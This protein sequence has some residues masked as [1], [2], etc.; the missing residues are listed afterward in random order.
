MYC[1]T[2][3]NKRLTYLLKGG[4][5]VTFCVLLGCNGEDIVAKANGHELTR[6]EAK[7]IMTKLGYNVNSQEEWKSFVNDWCLK[8]AMI[9]EL[10]ENGDENYDI[11]HIRSELFFGEMAEY[12]LT[13]NLLISQVDTIVSQDEMNEYYDSHTEEFTLQDFIVKVLYMK[14]PQKAEV[15]EQI[16]TAYLLK[17]DKDMARIESY[18]KLYAEDFYFDD[19]NWLFFSKIRNKLPVRNIDRESLVL[20]RTKTYFSD[21]QFVYFLNILDYKVKDDVS[22]MEFVEKEV[23]ERILTNR[24]NEKREKIRQQLNQEL[25]NKHEIEIYL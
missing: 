16:K 6:Y 4:L 3:A 25:K 9:D 5:L 8:M 11:A 20:N 13:E 2:L 1:I 21:D 10:K 15:L 22:P 23:K 19:Q 7:Q 24:M 18:A 14:V 12:Y 17:N